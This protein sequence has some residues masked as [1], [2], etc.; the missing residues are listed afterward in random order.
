MKIY[1]KPVDRS[2][3]QRVVVAKESDVFPDDVSSDGN[4]LVYQQV[5]PGRA[6]F[7]VLKAVSLKG[8]AKPTVV[9]DQIDALSDA[10]LMPGN[11]GWLAYQSSE[12][13]QPEVYLTRFP[14]PGARY[15]VSLAG[16]V[17]SVH[18]SARKSLFQTSLS[19][20]FD[21]SGYDVTRDG[22]FLMLDFVMETPSPVT[23]VMN[24]DAELKK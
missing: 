10:F 7:S 15:Q 1:A 18:V 13:G 6:Q 2:Q 19:L 11:N 20:S 24:W 21:E 12:S 22:R 17:E 8:E 4:W 3:A 23:V 9:L 5:Q 14:N 16:G